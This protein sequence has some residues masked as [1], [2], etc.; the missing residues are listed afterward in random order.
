MMV[1]PTI[2]RDKENPRMC[3]EL[4]RNQVMEQVHEEE[5][6]PQEAFIPDW[7]HKHPIDVR[8]CVTLASLILI[9]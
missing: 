7:A 6:F 9:R 2:I 1:K 5:T 8:K 3:L 4:N